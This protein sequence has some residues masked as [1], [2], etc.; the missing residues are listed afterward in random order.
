MPDVTAS[1]GKLFGFFYVCLV[2]ISIILF[3]IFYF[4]KNVK[5]NRKVF[6]INENSYINRTFTLLLFVS[7]TYYEVGKKNAF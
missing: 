5:K 7:T 3:T 1:Y 2:L 4:S 6:A